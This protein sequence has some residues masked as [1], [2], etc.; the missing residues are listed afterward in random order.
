MADKNIKITIRER[1]AIVEGSPVIVCGNSGY[2]LTF[3]FDD[4]WE[5]AGAKTARFVYVKDGEVKHEDIVF[6][7]IVAD[8]PILSNVAFVKVGVFAGDLRTTTPA[9]INCELSIL[10]GSGKVEEPTP[11]VYNQIMALLNDMT[12]NG[13]NGATEAQMKRVADNEKAIQDLKTGATRAGDAEKLG[14]QLPAYYATAQSVV[15]LEESVSDSLEDII[16]GTTPVAKAKDSEKLNGLTAEEFVANENLLINPDF[17]NP[18]NSSGK[19]SWNGNGTLYTFDKWILEG[20]SAVTL[21]LD[22]SGATISLNG[23]SYGSL[24]Y[25]TRN[26]LVSGEKYT[27]SVKYNGQI[28]SKTITGGSYIIGGSKLND[29]LTLF[30]LSS[31]GRLYLRTTATDSAVFEWAKLELGSVATPFV[32]P[33]K[34]VEKLKCGAVVGN[35]DTVD[36]YHASQ[37][38]TANYKNGYTFEIAYGDH[39]YITNYVDSSIPNIPFT[40]NFCHIIS[41]TSNSV[42]TVL[43]IGIDY[44]GLTYVYS[45][46]TGAWKRFSYSDEVLP[47]T[48][49]TLASA[50]PNP[51]NVHNTTE[52]ALFSLLGFY[53]NNVSM[54]NLGFYGKDNPVLYTSA[55][56]TKELLHAGN[57]SPVVPTNVDPGVGASVTYADGTVIFVYE[58]E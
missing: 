48:G 57:S 54:G 18:V 34:A 39:A 56:A 42:K 49:G 26:L 53:A 52:G 36:G 9:R 27:L 11:D 55:G 19:T 6:T 25:E 40:S 4:E 21:V 35:A 15:D 16:D 51:L 24:I 43:S 50:K 38:V 31:N 45:A 58:E 47:L 29:T 30:Y 20:T 13:G 44:T 1:R 23:A 37:L 10:C 7:G 3:T 5:Q 17:K 32:P 22:E 41:K 14:G 46:K 33:N 28:Y 12:V 8:V 2:T